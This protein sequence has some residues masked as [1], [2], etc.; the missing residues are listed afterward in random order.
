MSRAAKPAYVCQACGVRS[1]KWSGRCDDC[2]AWNSLNEESNVSPIH[3]NRKVTPAPIESLARDKNSPPIGRRQTN[4]SELDRTLGGGIVAGSAIL[5][6]GEPGIGKSTLTLQAATAL[7]KNYSV[8]Y[9]SGEEAAEQIRI[10]A[11]RLDVS[12]SELALLTET[13]LNKILAAFATLKPD[14]VIIDSVQTMWLDEVDGVAGTITQL[15]AST[16]ALVHFAKQTGAAVLLIGHSTKDG[17]IAGPNVIAHMVDVVMQFEGSANHQFRILRVNKN[18]YGAA[19][20]IGV[21]EMARA[22]LTPILNPSSLFL[23]EGEAEMSG[24]AVF[25][26][27]EGTRPLLVEIQALTTPSHYGQARRAVVGCEPARLSML[28]AVLEAR[29][30]LNFSGQDVYLNVAGGLRIT[31]PAADL[32]IAAALTSALLNKAWDKKSVFFGEISLSGAVRAAARSEA[33]LKEAKKL[34]WTQVFSPQ[35]TKLLPRCYV[36]QSVNDLQAGLSAIK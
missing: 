25:A 16:Q 13:N 1:F 18:R 15:R 23:G 32:A 19:D 28:L 2:G 8:A 35:E 31:D 20:E 21:F 6:G 29:A 3:K 26:A 7:A 36:V 30:G 27:I 33:R 17:Q 10:R 5:L 12:E 9:V 34:G 24:A 22:G 14:V 4:I 11:Q